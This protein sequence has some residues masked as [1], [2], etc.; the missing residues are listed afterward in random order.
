MEEQAANRGKR[1]SFRCPTY[2]I[3]LKN[4]Y[5]GYPFCKW[6]N[7]GHSKNGICTIGDLDEFIECKKNM[8]SWGRYV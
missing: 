2:L 3:F 7:C 5:H 6:D 4:W 1:T 8:R